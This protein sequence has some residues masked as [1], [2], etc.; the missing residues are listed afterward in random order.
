MDKGHMLKQEVREVYCC[1]K[2]L[3]DVLP[4]W[5]RSYADEAE[6]ESPICEIRM[7][8]GQKP[9][10]CCR[11]GEDH[12]PER[13][14]TGGDITYVV[15]T[16]SQFSPY[17]AQ[18]LSQGFLTARGGH[19]IGICGE[20]VLRNGKVE[21]VKYIRSLCIRVARD[22]G[23]I[24]GK[25]LPQLKNGSA[26]LLGPPGSGKTTLLRDLIRC[27]SDDWK[28][29]ICAI[30]EREEL[31]PTYYGGCCF[32]TGQ[33]TDVLTGV[34][35]ESG[36]EMAVRTMSPQWVAV[37]EITGVKDCIA[38]ERSAYSGV[39]FLATAHGSGMEDLTKRPVYKRLL[40]SGL[41]ST[42]VLLHRDGNVTVKEMFA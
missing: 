15:N 28:Q 29:Q 41:F 34:P 21:G 10:F 20:F 5:L 38:M 24:G 18:S 40:E 39:H 23:G 1:W 32:E 14:V 27:I 35:K 37:D 36:I 42:T 16:A 22:I 17:A 33:R 3:L 26:L 8:L 30:D 7:V 25:I 6:K 19:R 31:F 2:E 13:R 11:D 9:R 4:V 12:T